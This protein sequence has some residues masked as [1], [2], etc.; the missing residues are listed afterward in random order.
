MVVVGAGIAGLSAAFALAGHVDVTVCEA[1]VIGTRGAS[2]LPAAL[3]NPH[4]GRTARAHPD[5]VAGLA[6][7]WRRDVALQESGLD[8]GAA[9]K[10]VLRIAATARQAD[11][12][13]DAPRDA[14]GVRFLEPEKVPVEYHAPHGALH[15]TDG[16]WVRPERLLRALAEAIRAAGGRVVEGVP[17]RRLTRTTGEWRI[18]TDGETHRATHVVLCTG[19]DEAPAIDGIRFS[20]NEPLVRV[21]GDVVGLLDPR[22]FATPVAGAVYGAWEDGTAWIGGNHRDPANVDP[23]AADR[24]RMSFGWF[25]PALREAPIAHTWSGVRLKRRGNRPLVRE[26]EEGMWFFGALAGRGFLCGALEAERLAAAI[27]T[28]W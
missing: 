7:F 24:L 6:A 18:E 15:V 3:L 5:D 26:V 19:A 21:A 23:S 25:V 8:G 22:G 4:R 2:S 16:G 12:W 28:R 11:L 27:R 14:T 1:G 9:R 10:G 17:V 13:R 20:G